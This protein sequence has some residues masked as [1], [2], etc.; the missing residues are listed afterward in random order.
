MLHSASQ[1][2]RIAAL[3]TVR[4]GNESAPTL[5]RLLPVLGQG[6]L[7]C[8]TSEQQLSR[9]ETN[10]L[11]SQL[12][13]PPPDPCARTGTR[14]GRGGGRG[15]RRTRDDRPDPTNAIYIGIHEEVPPSRTKPSVRHTWLHAQIG[16]EA[17]PTQRA[18][19]SQQ[20]TPFLNEFDRA[21][22]ERFDLVA[23]LDAAAMSRTTTSTSKD[24]PMRMR[25]YH[26]LMGTNSVRPADPYEIVT[27]YGPE[28]RR[29][30]QVRRLADLFSDNTKL[31]H[32]IE[33]AQSIKVA[34]QPEAR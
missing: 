10:R 15:G 9:A 26:I 29:H 12:F 21:L 14:G 18:D 1:V 33:A 34:V 8:V 27:N 11:V 23:F 16:R 24:T 5:P 22:A 25:T 31:N 17:A 13:P 7:L 19:A 28:V 6:T 20:Q 3:H 4:P 32:F 2:M 30:P